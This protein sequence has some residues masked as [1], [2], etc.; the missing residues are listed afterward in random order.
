MHTMHYDIRNALLAILLGASRQ[1]S[2]QIVSKISE[3]RLNLG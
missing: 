2:G 3:I 1:S